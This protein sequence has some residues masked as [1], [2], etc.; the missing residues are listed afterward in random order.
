MNEQDVPVAAGLERAVGLDRVVEADDR[1]RRAPVQD[2]PAGIE[3]L[4]EAGERVRGAPLEP[5]RRV[6]P[7]ARRR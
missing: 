2:P 3:P 1:G 4:G 7:Q 5:G 6:Q